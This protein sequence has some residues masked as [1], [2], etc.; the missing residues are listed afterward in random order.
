MT[1]EAIFNKGEQQAPVENKQE[2]I[3]IP[4]KEE[5]TSQPTKSSIPPELQDWVGEGKKYKSIED[6]YKAF[7]HS[8]QHIENL[9]NKVA[10]LEKELNSRKSAEEVLREIQ[11]NKTYQPK[12]TSQGV[13]VNE[14]VLSEI[15]RNELSLYKSQEQ[16]EA[17]WQTV[18]QAFV[19]AYKEKADDQFK[20]LAQENGMDVNDFISLARKNPK[21]ILNAAGLN[22]KNVQK[23]S[24]ESSFNSQAIANNNNAQQDEEIS[25]RVGAY[26]SSK[27]LAE[28]WRNASEKVKRQ[29]K[30]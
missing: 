28:A 10:E 29:M 9:N 7:P 5:A 15:V 20:T 17:N 23:P 8:Q 19:G 25:A 16:Q 1:E 24:I 6:V 22:K 14:N 30:G 4:S 21:L 11:E 18:E 12:P 2:G 27:D 26:A 3:Q 13:E